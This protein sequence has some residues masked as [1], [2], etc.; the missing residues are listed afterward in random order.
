MTK[1]SLITISALAAACTLAAACALATSSP[2]LAATEFTRVSFT[3]LT[4]WGFEEPAPPLCNPGFNVRTTWE[5]TPTGHVTEETNVLGQPVQ[6]IWKVVHGT[7]TFTCPDGSTFALAFD[8]L[9]YTF[10]Y[11]IGCIQEISRYTGV[12]RVAGGTGAYANLVG[13][14][15]LNVGSNPFSGLILHYSG[16][17]G[18]RFVMPQTAAECKNGGWEGFDVFKNQG[19]CVSWVATGGK[20]EAGK[21]EPTSP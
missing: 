6:A 5:A 12:W 8:L 20:N 18:F 7:Q 10:C 11:S 1:R 2:A 13:G 3:S 14:G 19:D 4:Y 9:G 15:T 16:E 21:N 17:V